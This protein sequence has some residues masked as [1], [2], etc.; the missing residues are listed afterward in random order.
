MDFTKPIGLEVD[1]I[2]DAEC[3]EIWMMDNNVEFERRI[4]Q[5]ACHAYS[6]TIKDED[7]LKKIKNLV[8]P[9]VYQSGSNE[10]C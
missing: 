1:N 4:I 6:C 10:S 8:D 9:L 5:P 2:D 3:L 7:T